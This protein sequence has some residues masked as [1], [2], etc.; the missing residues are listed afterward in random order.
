M[1]CR[2]NLDKV[3]QA[4]LVAGIAGGV[5]L[6][7]A[8]RMAAARSI[9][10]GQKLRQAQRREQAREQERQQYA[11]AKAAGKFYDPLTR[12]VTDQKYLVAGRY[13]WQGQPQLDKIELYHAGQARLLA[14]T[15]GYSLWQVTA[16]KEAEGDLT[17]RLTD[18]ATGEEFSSP[19]EPYGRR[20]TPG[21]SFEAE[22]TEANEAHAIID[23]HSNRVVRA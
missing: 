12:Q 17:Y 20:Q 16:N 13:L 5:S 11:E 23:A 21:G 2:T 7:I 8:T 4:A 15:T 10:Q 1:S 3:K 18:L 22:R 14:A 9:R 19:S 6:A